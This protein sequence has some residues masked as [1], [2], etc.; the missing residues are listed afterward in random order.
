MTGDSN[1]LSNIEKCSGPKISFGNSSKGKIVGK[2]KV[3]HGNIKLNDVFLVENLDYNLIS[4]SQL[5]DSGHIVNFQKHECQIKNQQGITLVTGKRIGNTYKMNWISN[6]SKSICLIAKND[7]NWLWHK[8][9][10]HLNFKTI[11]KLSSDN[12]VIGI[13]KLKFNKDKICAA[14]QMGKQTKSSFKSKGSIQSNRYLELLHMDLFG[15][16]PI[17]SLGGK[18]YCLVVI[19]DYSRFTWVIFLKSKDETCF[20]LIKLIKQI[21]NEKSLSVIKIRSDRGTEFLNKSLSSFLEE[22]GIRHELS[23]ARTPQQNGIAERKNRTLKEAGRTMLADSG[24]SQRFWAEAINTACYTQ[25]RSLIHKRFDKTPYE[26]VYEKVPTIGYFKIFGSDCFIHNNGKNHLTAFDAKADIGIMVGYSLVSKAYRVYNKKTK[27]IEESAH[28]IF[29]ESFEETQNKIDDLSKNFEKI[30]I[31]SNDDDDEEFDSTRETVFEEPVFVQQT[32]NNQQ[33]DETP[34][35]QLSESLSNQLNNRLNIQQAEINQQ[36]DQLVDPLGPVYR[37]NRNHPLELVIGS[38][39]APVRTRNQINTDSF[40]SAFISQIEPKKI[41]DALLDP[42]WIL[43]MQEEL[44][45]FVRQN[46]W[47]L[48]PRPDGENIIGTRWVFRNKLNEDGQV[49]RNKARLVAQGYK[50]EEGI[51]YDESFAPVARLEA[52]RIFLAFASFKNFKVYQMDVKSAFLNGILNEE[53]YVEQPPG[54]QDHTVPNSVFKLDKALYGLKQAPRAWYETLTKFLFEHDFIVGSVDK[55]L[56]KFTKDTHI[57]LVQIYV[58]DIIF[59]S[60]N[61]KLCERFSK[62]M[63]ERFEMSMMGE[64]SYFLGLQVRQLEEGTFISQTKYTRELIK[65]FGMEKSS[66]TS[67]PMSPSIK[68]DKDEEGQNVD[69]T[70]Y[71][72]IIGSLL[73][74]TASRPDISFAVGVCGRFQANPKLSHFTA[75]KRILKY[76]RGTESVGLWYPKDSSFNLTSYSDADYAGCKVDRK[77]TSGTCQFLGDRLISWNSKKQTSIATS[78]AEAEYLAAGSCCSQLLWVQQQLKDYGVQAEE[79]PIFCDNTSAIAITYNPVLHSRTKHIDIRHHFIRDHVSLKHIRLEYIPTDNQVA[80]IFTKPLP[81]A[82]FSFFRN[83]LGLL[84]L[85]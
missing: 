44:N 29:D 25:N 6:S 75:A 71:R 70:A 59:G 27:S 22:S 66:P 77:S 79:S 13:P 16:T 41:A 52:I 9:L 23:S 57:L 26:I 48:V 5:C 14:C 3:T 21:Q 80:D 18:S 10:N 78:T 4:I 50:Q 11:N 38:P 72:G 68:L 30:S 61:P 31:L 74:L 8:R 76:L 42:D 43:A 51:D 33:T 83:S 46:V 15:P 54:F 62:L 2:G 49:V 45:E 67:T 56:F 19:D 28:V 81:E 53:V 63:Q 7:Q 17:T 58:D 85:N 12:L 73:Y 1:L 47:H 40:N 34:V 65:K 69:M 32:I 37:T 55:T 82:K 24:I 35:N 20:N 39:S 84:D 64:L 36:A 60:T